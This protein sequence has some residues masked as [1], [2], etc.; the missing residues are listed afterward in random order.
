MSRMISRC[1]SKPL[2][3]RLKPTPI[4]PL[5]QGRNIE[6]VLFGKGFRIRV[7]FLMFRSRERD[8]RQIGCLLPEAMRAG[9]ARIAAVL[10]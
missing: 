2:P 4:Q 10:P 1:E 9:V 6:P 7:V 5:D 3:P 8:A